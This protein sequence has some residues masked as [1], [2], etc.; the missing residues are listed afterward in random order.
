MTDT[1]ET[2]DAIESLLAEGRTFPP[3]PSFVDAARIT[4]AAIYAEADADHEAF[5]AA[6]AEELV[7]WFE[8]WHTVLDWDLPFA[9][10]FVGG[11]LN[12]AYN[13][14]DRHVEAGHGEK[15]AYFWEAESGPGRTIT[16]RELLEE[17]CRLA[18]A[19]KALG[20]EKGDRVNVYLGMVPELPISL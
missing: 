5:W 17:V 14:L 18:N 3:P 7:T 20:V 15:V 9:Q 4:D 11:K 8:P 1:H 19:L 10:W 16:Y 12:V 13:C 6:Q 2:H